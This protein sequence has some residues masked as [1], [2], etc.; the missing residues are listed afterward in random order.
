ML[1]LFRRGDYGNYCGCLLFLTSE[2]W[3]HSNVGGRC[4][5][6]CTWSKRTRPH[7]SPECPKRQS[8]YGRYR[9][10]GLVF[11]YCYNTIYIFQF[12]VPTP[13]VVTRRSDT[14]GHLQRGTSRT[15]KA[16][17]FLDLLALCGP[18]PLD[19]IWIVSGANRETLVMSFTSHESSFRVP[20]DCLMMAAH[21]VLGLTPCRA[22]HVQKSP[23]C[24]GS[25]VD[26]RGSSS[27]ST[28]SLASMSLKRTPVSMLMGHIPRCACS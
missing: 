10:V 8:T 12:Q 9:G 6:R 2:E 27:S 22:S 24:N 23:R 21:R 1:L 26:R 5:D 7:R 18:S 17:V 16:R 13:Y 25:P 15:L 14:K 4:V 3:Q 11:R 20:C 19:Y 28:S